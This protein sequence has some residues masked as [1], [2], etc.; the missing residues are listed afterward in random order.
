M[1]RSIAI[2]M[3][4]PQYPEL[5]E[6]T[7]LWCGN[8]TAPCFEKYE[9]TPKHVDRIYF[10]DHIDVLKRNSAAAERDYVAD[11]NSFGCPVYSTTAYPELEHGVALPIRDMV[12]TV[13]HAYFTC[14]TAYM[15]AHAAYEDMRGDRIERVIVAGMY[16]EH[17][18]AEYMQH[19]ACIN[20][21]LG[22]LMGR[23]IQIEV[24]GPSMV[25]K[26]WPWESTYYGYEQNTLYRVSAKA[27]GAV[28]DMCRE[29]P[30]QWH[31]EESFYEQGLRNPETEDCVPPREDTQS[32]DCGGSE[33]EREETADQASS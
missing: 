2:F 12:Q 6:E 3:A 7:E 13:G 16:Y 1:A 9:Y 21:W 27:L 29:L 11:V 23:G 14:T 15:L 8:N 10:T 33:S 20:M 26:A 32:S 30:R 5:S 28:Y 4:I 31:R 17:D 22:F 18:S 24:H 25:L 19:I